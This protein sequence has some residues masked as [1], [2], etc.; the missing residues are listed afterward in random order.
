MRNA[1]PIAV[2]DRFTVRPGLTTTLDLLANDRDPNTGQALSIASLGAPTKGTV[3][4][5][6]DGTVGYRPMR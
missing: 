2:D 4:R 6:A 1:A 5:N 3:T